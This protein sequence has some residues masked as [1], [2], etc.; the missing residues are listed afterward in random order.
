MNPSTKEF[1]QSY[2][3]LYG[4]K[5]FF[6]KPTQIVENTLQSLKAKL[7]ANEMIDRLNSGIIGTMSYVDM[8]TAFRLSSVLGTNP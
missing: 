1:Q 8:K 3:K 6:Y 4:K 5:F 2:S 7:D